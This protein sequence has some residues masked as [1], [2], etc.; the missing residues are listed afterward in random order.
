MRHDANS[1]YI[2]QVSDFH[3]S[4]ESKDSAK[5]ALKAVTD[6]I[7]EMKIDI[8]Y[9]I[10]TGDIINS[11]DINQ[12]IEEKYGIELK[13]E[14]YDKCLDE[15]VLQRFEIAK[16]IFGEFEEKLDVM[17]KNIVICC[18]NHDKVRYRTR[19]ED[20]FKPFQNF[21]KNVCSHT[22][23]TDLFKLDDINV[24]VLN[25][26]ISD[27]KKVTCVDCENL[28]EVLNVQLHEEQPSW[29]YTYGGNANISV[30]E[31]KVN[32]IVAHQ[33]L[34]DICEQIRL[35]YGSETQ[36]TDFLSAL[37]TLR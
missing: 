23:L 6:K 8:R 11:K 9:L 2:L 5:N 29:F 21:L 19:K 32:V 34:Y 13:N 26:N 16:E 30:E 22:K 3:I 37:S 20:A 35:P 24:L 10:H 18:G 14:E 33:P 17:R 28:K 15:I 36:T 25:T 27:D 7:K 4:E 1:F 12:K 31:S